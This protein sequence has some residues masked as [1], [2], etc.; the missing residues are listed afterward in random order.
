MGCAGDAVRGGVE[1]TLRPGARLE[2][3]LRASVES[4]DD[5]E[6]MLATFNPDQDRLDY[7]L[8]FTAMTKSYLMNNL[9]E[10][11]PNNGALDCL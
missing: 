5:G 8:A 2:E 1:F 3:A 10:K 11:V 6:S 7:S 4:G 9:I